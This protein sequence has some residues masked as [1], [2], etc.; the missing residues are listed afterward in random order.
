MN[1]FHIKKI[2]FLFTIFVLFNSC[3]AA[4]ANPPSIVES[5]DQPTAAIQ[6]TPS[7]TATVYLPLIQNISEYKFFGIY[8]KEYWT[9]ENVNT[10]M[11]QVDSYTGK[12]HT[13]VG[14][15]IDIEDPAFSLP[16]TYMPNN[17]LYRQL[18][19][20]WAE[21]YVS[22]IN[23]G[24]KSTA[25]EIAGGMR[26]REI[27]Y[28]ADYYKLWVDQGGGRKALIAPLQ[29]MNGVYYDGTTWT[30]YAGDQ[31]NFKLAY[32][33]IQNIFLQKEISRDQVWWTF[34]PNGWS[35]DDGKHD[36]ELYYPG[37]D[38]V[39]VIGFSSYNYGFCPGV[40]AR[41]DDTK[42]VL[43]EY[44]DRM[45]A[46]APSKPIII[47]E[48]ATSA[49]YGEGLFDDEHKNQ[50][51]TDTYGYLAGRPSVVGVYYF[52]FGQFDGY[53]CDFEIIE[54]KA[55][56]TTHFYE[57][58]KTGLSSSKYLYLTTQDLDRLLK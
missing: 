4:P 6:D 12:K 36:F 35:T 22:F 8:F 34:A 23:L 46:M 54:N 15:F 33:R 21:G 24:S 40:S 26:D 42:A 48:T 16:V 5:T 20:L 17:N 44:I 37:D 47:A 14:W 9:E 55:D 19:S 1:Q 31:E 50:W 32:K 3:S 43:E 41:W 11:S 49:Y 7:P 29:E 45:E 30:T 27:G 51:L 57:G 52:S 28:L 53:T 10:V 58:Y 39:D 13:S 18:E 2:F 56:G 38:F 25:A